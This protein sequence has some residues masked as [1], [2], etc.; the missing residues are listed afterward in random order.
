MEQRM[1]MVRAALIVVF[2]MMM[3]IPFALAEEASEPPQVPVEL[4]GKLLFTIQA[5]TN[6]F[7]PQLRAAQIAARIKELASDYTFRPER[8]TTSDLGF[9]TEISGDERFIMAVFDADAKAEEQDREALAKAHAMRIRGAIEAYREE[10]SISNM[11]IGLGLTLLSTVILVALI[12]LLNRSFRK[13]RQ[14]VRET[15]RVP[16]A[17][18]GSFEFFTA[19]RIKALILALVRL[20]RLGVLLVFLFAYFQL[21]LS[22]FPATRRI[23]LTIYDY[24]WA[25]LGTIG[26]AMV[27]QLPGLIFI[28][29]LIFIT[30]YLLKT[31]K[32]FFQQVQ[33]GKVT[34]GD[35]DAEVAE[36]SYKIIRLLIIAFALVVAYP[37]IPG[38]ESPAFKG[39]SIFMGVIFSLGSSSAV[40]GMTAGLS[41]IY[42][43]SF[44][45]GDVVKIGEATGIVL[46]RKLMVTRLKTFKNEEISIPNGTILSSQVVNYS[47]QARG[48]GVIL[49]TSVTIGYDAP[50][51]TVHGLLIKAAK[52]TSRILEEPQPFVLQTALNDFYVSYELNAYTDSPQFMPRIY[53]ELH[54]NIQERFN[55][56]GVEILSPHYAQLRDGNAT[57]IPKSYLPEDYAAPALRIVDTTVLEKSKKEQKEGE[58]N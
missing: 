9:A 58:K 21:G 2:F 3:C 35:L 30:R 31:L 1:K 6:A 22:F 56:G 10:R 47:Q 16:S 4:D 23:A 45:E 42:M 48:E 27:D 33:E 18:F 15:S 34:I 28:V 38:S 8:I 12:Y 11:V 13:L 32:F 43:R 19:S 41:L 5:G 57:A 51:Q 52:T 44:R 26:N 24:V 46:Q 14:T 25:A 40:A 36:P 29:I 39:V 53:S 49:H 7:T 17:R 54:Q 55:E 37:Y 20:I 50:W